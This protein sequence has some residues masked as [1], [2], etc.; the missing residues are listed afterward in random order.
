VDVDGTNA[1][2][3]LGIADVKTGLR[4]VDVDVVEQAELADAGSGQHKRRGD[5]SRD[6]GCRGSLVNAAIEV[7]SCGGRHIK[8][9]SDLVPRQ[10][11]SVTKVA[12][13]APRSSVERR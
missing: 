12:H 3:R 4:K 11:L 2:V 7:H 9:S 1:G 5:R 10:L 13:N 6:S 8:R